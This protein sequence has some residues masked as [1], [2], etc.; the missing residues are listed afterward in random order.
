MPRYLWFHAFSRNTLTDTFEVLRNGPRHHP[1][2]AVRTRVNEEHLGIAPPCVYAYLG[3]TLETFGTSAISLPQEDV[4]GTCTPFDSGGLVDHIAPIRDWAAGSRRSYLQRF[5]WPSTQLIDRLSEYPT[6]DPIRVADYLNGVRPS[7][8]G[9]H[10]LWLDAREISEGTLVASIWNDNVDCR[11][12]LWEARVPN[13]IPI[14][15]NLVKWSCS[16][17][18]HAEILEYTERIRDDNEAQW[19][20]SLLEKFVVGGVSALILELRAF[21]EAAA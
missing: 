13:R 18:T 12:W 2:P 8:S 20:E 11:S 21:Q 10:Q 17:A 16:S 19:V 15:N 6:R 3:R 14:E 9:P 7:E 5:S 4:V 1:D